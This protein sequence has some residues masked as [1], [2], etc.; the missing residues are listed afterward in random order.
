MFASEEIIHKNEK[1]LGT[2]GSISDT[3]PYLGF[4]SLKLVY[5][6]QNLVYDQTWNLSKNRAK[7]KIPK[8]AST[9]SAIIGTRE[10]WS[11][12][13]LFFY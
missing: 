7:A 5:T 10:L 13:L 12:L 8:F 1:I 9:F 2:F 6:N 4:T 11:K 3:S